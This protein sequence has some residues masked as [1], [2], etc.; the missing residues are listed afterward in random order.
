MKVATEVAC[1][2]SRLTLEFEGWMNKLCCAYTES[3]N[4]FDVDQAGPLALKLFQR[5]PCSLTARLSSGT[6]L[7]L[8]PLIRVITSCDSEYLSVVPSSYLRTSGLYVTKTSNRRVFWSKSSLNTKSIEGHS[9]DEPASRPHPDIGHSQS[10][11]CIQLSTL[12]GMRLT[13]VSFE[14]KA[15]STATKRRLL[16][17]LHPSRLTFKSIK[18]NPHHQPVTQKLAQSTPNK[19]ANNHIS[20]EIHGQ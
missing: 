5:H 15:S 3:L 8:P 16:N 1:L 10:L 14:I 17:P 18:I 4:L 2:T 11:S 13:L 19:Y 12:K 20:I 7:P 6:C 9:F